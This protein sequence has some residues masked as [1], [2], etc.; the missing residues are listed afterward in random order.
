M[1]VLE[2]SLIVFNWTYC[3]E[4]MHRTVAPVCKSLYITPYIQGK[5]F[6]KLLLL[7]LLTRFVCFRAWFQFMLKVTK[8]F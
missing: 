3:K 7:F 8:G 5:Q 4:N 6:S 2:V 1:L